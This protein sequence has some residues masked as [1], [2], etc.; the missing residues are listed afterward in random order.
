MAID[1]D[2]ENYRKFHKNCKYCKHAKYESP[3]LKYNVSCPDYYYCECS[4]NVIHIFIKA[5]WCR[6]YRV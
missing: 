4:D 1:K 3:V 6:Y 2:V 5:L